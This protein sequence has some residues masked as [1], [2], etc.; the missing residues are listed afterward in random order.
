MARLKTITLP[1][2][3][4][5]RLLFVIDKAF[6]GSPL[7]L[8]KAAGVTRA[9]VNNWPPVAEWLMDPHISKALDHE[10][11]AADERARMLFELKM[12]FDHRIIKQRQDL[13]A[14]L[15]AERQK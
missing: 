14:K 8:A 10:I 15:R 4:A 3:A 13:E 5:E 6:A 7:A 1:E 9:A 2:D 11:K 12:A